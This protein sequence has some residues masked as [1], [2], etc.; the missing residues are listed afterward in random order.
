MK[1]DDPV[2][3]TKGRVS[4]SPTIAQNASRVWAGS[5]SNQRSNGCAPVTATRSAGMP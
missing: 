3:S 4:G 2:K 5:R 1:T